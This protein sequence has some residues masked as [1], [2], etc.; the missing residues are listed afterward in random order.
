M[1]IEEPIVLT[2]LSHLDVFQGLT[3]SL[4][5]SG[6]I[7]TKIYLEGN[8]A[9]IFDFEYEGRG[10]NVRFQA[11]LDLRWQRFYFQKHTQSPLYFGSLSFQESPFL[12]ER[13]FLSEIQSLQENK[14]FTDSMDRCEVLMDEDDLGYILRLLH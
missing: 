11:T 4:S 2:R 10:T 9:L 13:E 14:D 12:T 8:R 1:N 3:D 7:P 5:S 6:I